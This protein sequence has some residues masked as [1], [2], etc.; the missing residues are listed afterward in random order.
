[1]ATAQQ[2][3]T[4]QELVSDPR[5][6]SLPFDQRRKA[7]AGVDNDFAKLA[8]PDQV[9]A[10]VGLGQKF[11][12]AQQS[13][14][15]AGLASPGKAPVVDM[16]QQP[17]TAL[18]SGMSKV[19]QAT[20]GAIGTLDSVGDAGINKANDFVVGVAQSGANALYHSGKLARALINR[21]P[22]VRDAANAIAPQFPAQEPP[23]LN[24]PVSDSVLADHNPPAMQRA[25]RFAGDA[26]QFMMPAGKLA[27]GGKIIDAAVNSQKLPGMVQALLRLGG[28]G[29]LEG[30][31]TGAITAGQGGDAEQGAALGA[32][33]PALNAGLG[34]LSSPLKA[35]ALTQYEKFLGSNLAV[36]G[37]AERSIEHLAGKLAPTMLEKGITGS[38]SAIAKRAV[39]ESLGVGREIGNAVD[40]IPPDRKVATQGIIDELDKLKEQY[41][42]QRK[43]FTA[44]DFA[45][46]K[47]IR[48]AGNGLVIDYPIDEAAFNR[49][50]NLQDVIAVH[51]PE[52]SYADLRKIR[53]LWDSQVSA[54]NG[55]MG[56][57]FAEG[58]DLKVKEYGAN[59]IRD[60]LSK[61]EPS[62]DELNGRFSF[63][64]NVERV[65]KAKNPSESLA[66]QIKNGVIDGSISAV[67]GGGAGWVAGGPKLA[68]LT[69]ATAGLFKAVTSRP[70]WATTSAVLKDRLAEQ[71]AAGNQTGVTQTL[72]RIL[73]GTTARQSQPAQ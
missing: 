28:R 29:A 49:V 40:A 58:S 38:E 18:Q 24:P 68:V 45:N 55:Y 71:I 23:D 41:V 7:L 47:R 54:G 20:S 22:G 59:A 57:T 69:G 27:E 35:A 19:G 60:V 9:R 46:G 1:M 26:Y 63:W 44:Q 12:P 17:M 16:Q 62:I 66:N 43:P 3:P 73:A 2:L 31:A 15:N 37:V 33:G 32:F 70:A 64:K 48:A 42:I 4:P 8:L 36:N 56:K 65:M 52:A 30:A 72:V 39:G 14:P 5:F 11:A 67:A 10:L 6:H 50:Q 34:K 53:Q 13:A 61:A 51:G 21:V 25:G